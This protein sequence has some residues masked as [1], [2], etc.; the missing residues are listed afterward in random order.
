VAQS[1][2]PRLS[3]QLHA[4]VQWLEATDVERP[5][6]FGS[7][8]EY[9]WLLRLA[10]MVLVL[11]DRHRVDGQGRCRQCGLSRDGWRRL[12]PLWGQRSPCRVRRAAV[13]FMHAELAVLWWQVFTLRGD[14]L[15]LDDVRAWLAVQQISALG[16][17]ASSTQEWLADDEGT[18]GR[19]ALLTDARVRLREEAQPTAADADRLSVRPYVQPE[20]PTAHL[21]AAA[22]EPTEAPTDVLPKITER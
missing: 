15:D 10:A 16:A 8:D 12:I 7:Q 9:E 21:P 13:F 4:L 19:H 22:A 1:G 11:L 3:D 2:R 20:F 5:E 18:G 17:E 6:L 14:R